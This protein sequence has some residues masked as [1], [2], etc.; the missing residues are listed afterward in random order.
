MLLF[1]IDI[2][3]DFSTLEAD[4]ELNCVEVYIIFSSKR[5]VFLPL[6]L[7]KECFSENVFFEH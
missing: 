2:L 3:F 7:T 1:P 6:E 5:I 4:N